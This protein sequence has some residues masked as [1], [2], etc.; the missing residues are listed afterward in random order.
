MP[1][2]EESM[3]KVKRIDGGIEMESSIP[4]QFRSIPFCNS[5]SNSNSM[6]CNSYSNSGIGIGIEVNS[7]SNSG[8][9]P[10]PALYET[11]K[12]NFEESILDVQSAPEQGL[13]ATGNELEKGMTLR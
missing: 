13:P 12:D 3:A 1:L 6:A 4:F 11:A 7:N 9:D 10:S 5:N 2:V 8:I